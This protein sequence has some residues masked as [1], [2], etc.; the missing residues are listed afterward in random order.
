MKYQWLNHNYTV[1]T[2][3]CSLDTFHFLLT[4]ISFFLRSFHVY[5][6][7]FT[8]KNMENN[9]NQTLGPNETTPTKYEKGSRFSLVSSVTSGPPVFKMAK[10]CKLQLLEIPI[11]GS[12]NSP[13]SPLQLS[14]PS[15]TKI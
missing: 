13:E 11:W 4:F 9:T 14:L 2:H 15:A 3:T 12:I 1:H 5:F 8:H 10:I 7:F 6:V